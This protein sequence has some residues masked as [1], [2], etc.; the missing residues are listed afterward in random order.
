MRRLNWREN[1]FVVWRTFSSQ[2]RASLGRGGAASPSWTF[3]PR[4]II[5]LV[6][7]RELAGTELIEEARYYDK[8]RSRLGKPFLEEANRKIIEIQKV[9]CHHHEEVSSIEKVQF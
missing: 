9:L 4:E 5:S 2:E 6:T 1:Y 8:K 3:E 7:F